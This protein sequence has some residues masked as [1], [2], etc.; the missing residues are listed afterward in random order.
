MKRSNWYIL[1]GLSLAILSIII[2]SAHYLIFRD[3]H[4]IFIYLLGD[5]AFIPL[6][7]LIVALFIDKFLEK[8]EKYGRIKKMNMVIGA[9]FTEVGTTLLKEFSK[10]DVNAEKIKKELTLEKDWTE[11][12]FNDVSKKIKTL[13][14]VTNC[15]K[16]DIED[17]R[18]ILLD[19]RNFILLILQNPNLLEHESF[20]ELLW[21]VMHLTEELAKRKDLKNLSGSDNEHLSNDIKRAYTQILSEWLDYMKHLKTTYPFLFS[22][23]LRTNPFDEN[24]KVEIK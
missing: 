15:K 4:H 24:A 21:A 10:F 20:T 16:D 14:Y 6:E 2:Y 11:K 7:V 19:K 23:A 12:E 17:L 18:T 5:I 1:F 22:L 9:F 3:A 8:H 13:E